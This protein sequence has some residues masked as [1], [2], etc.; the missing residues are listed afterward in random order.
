MSYIILT[1]ILI[2]V[3]WVWAYHRHRHRHRPP[4]K[5]QE[6]A[7]PRREPTPQVKAKL[8]NLAGSVEEAERQVARA[9]FADPGRSEAWYWWKAI[10]NLTEQAR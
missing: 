1:I 7:L 8:I 6:L 10:Q 5:F 3:L 9:R 4:T 2:L